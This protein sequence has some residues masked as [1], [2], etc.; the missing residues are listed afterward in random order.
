MAEEKVVYEVRDALDWGLVIGWQL[1]ISCST[2]CRKSS[3]SRFTLRVPREFDSV[4]W[5]LA[6]LR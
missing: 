4:E 5:T 6:Q 2:S 3:T 1:K